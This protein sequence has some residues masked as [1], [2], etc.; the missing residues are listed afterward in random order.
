M[1]RMLAKKMEMYKRERCYKCMSESDPRN[2]E[3]QA[4]IVKELRRVR[5]CMTVATICYTYSAGLGLL[6]NNLE[7]SGRVLI[8][9]ILTYV[10]AATYSF[11]AHRAGM[12]KL[13]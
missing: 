8:P 11:A 1:D 6:N 10:V 12:R 4:L 5:N 13:E 3:T 7:H 9:A 2:Y